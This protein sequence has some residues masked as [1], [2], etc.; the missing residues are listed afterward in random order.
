MRTLDDGVEKVIGVPLS[1]KLNLS[2]E[3]ERSPVPALGGD[4]GE[5]CSSPCSSLIPGN[6][7]PNSVA[8]L[9]PGFS[10]MAAAMNAA[11][12]STAFMES[13]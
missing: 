4:A 12:D 10:C 7:T 2:I 6:R 1:G 5:D 8:I 9:G 13:A 3:V 11:T